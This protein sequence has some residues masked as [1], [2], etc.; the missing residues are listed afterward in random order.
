MSDKPTAPALRLL[1]A[2]LLLSALSIGCTEDM[3]VRPQPAFVRFDSLALVPMGGQNWVTHF[4]SNTG[5]STAYRVT[6][7]WHSASDDSVRASS[8]E[9][10]DVTAGQGAHAFTM[11]A[12]NPAWTWP[13]APDSIRWSDIP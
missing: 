5:G 2:A 6:A 4:V 1:G 13:T 7:Y 10:I 9:P 3:P 8:T 12:D 11:P